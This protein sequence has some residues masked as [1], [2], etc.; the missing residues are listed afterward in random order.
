MNKVEGTPT[1]S[2]QSEASHS[3]FPRVSRRNPSPEDRRRLKRL[4]KIALCHLRDELQR[5]EEIYPAADGETL[6][7]TADI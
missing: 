1:N 6:D 2:V 3:Q 5:L 4:S 7:K